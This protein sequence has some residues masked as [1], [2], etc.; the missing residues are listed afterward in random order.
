MAIFCFLCVALLVG[1]MLAAAA[2]ESPF[3]FGDYD[4]MKNGTYINGCKFD[5]EK[6]APVA[7]TLLSY[8]LLVLTSWFCLGACINAL[9]R[10]N[11]WLYKNR[12]TSFC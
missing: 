5:K 2:F 8:V 11:P 1:L 10:N 3:I 9:T 7:L 4:L 6:A 12:R